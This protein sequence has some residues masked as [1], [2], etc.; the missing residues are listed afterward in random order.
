M[1]FQELN[2]ANKQVKCSS[3]S[4]AKIVGTQNFIWRCPVAMNLP[5]KKN[6]LLQIFVTSTGPATACVL[7]LPSVV[8]Q[9]GV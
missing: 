2:P 6:V 7:E 4:N 9:Q 8:G 1:I 5:E 3:D